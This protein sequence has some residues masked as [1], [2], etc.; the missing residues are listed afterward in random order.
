MIKIISLD[1]KKEI[2]LNN[3]QIPSPNLWIIDTLIGVEG[4]FDPSR[5]VQLFEFLDV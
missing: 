3:K 4:K 1:S 2:D 5:R